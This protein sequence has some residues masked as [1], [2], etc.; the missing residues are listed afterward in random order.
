MKIVLVMNVKKVAYEL[1]G[2]SAK[3]GAAPADNDSSNPLENLNKNI[4]IAKSFD[5]N[6]LY[7]YQKL[8]DWHFIVVSMHTRRQNMWKNL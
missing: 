3:V 1:S 8:L 4:F 5:W 6:I 7:S 2:P